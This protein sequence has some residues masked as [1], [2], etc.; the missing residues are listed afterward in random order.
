MIGGIVSKLA[1]DWCATCWGAGRIMEPSRVLM[2]QEG[3]GEAMYRTF[4]YWPVLCPAC[5]GRRS[6]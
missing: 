1:S 3:S 6:A 2:I 4:D 5:E